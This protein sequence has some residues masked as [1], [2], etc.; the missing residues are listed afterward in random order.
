MTCWKEQIM[1]WSSWM[2]YKNYINNHG[3]SWMNKEF[4]FIYFMSYNQLQHSFYKSTLRYQKDMTWEWLGSV[5]IWVKNVPWNGRNL[6]SK[7]CRVCGSEQRSVWNEIRSMMTCAQKCPEMDRD[8]CLKIDRKHV[9]KLAEKNVMRWEEICLKDTKTCSQKST[10]ACHIVCL[11]QY[12]HQW[13]QRT[14]GCYSVKEYFK[15]IIHSKIS[16]YIYMTFTKIPPPKSQR[17]AC[18]S[19]NFPPSHGSKIQFPGESIRNAQSRC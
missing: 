8:I 18:W 6:C 16:S 13:E 14:A 1:N 10:D 19:W 2:T 9:H 11:P 7:M 5:L 3:R 17:H 12:M 15:C 4:V